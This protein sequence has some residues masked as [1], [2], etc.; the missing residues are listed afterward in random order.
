MFVNHS[1]GPFATDEEKFGAE[2][3]LTVGQKGVD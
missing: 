3:E 1:V 2:T